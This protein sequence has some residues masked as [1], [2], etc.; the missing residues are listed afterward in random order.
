MRRLALLC[1][2]ILLPLEGWA[3]QDVANTRHN[4]STSGPGT[5]KSTS[6]TQVCVFCHTPH[7]AQPDAPLWNRQMS[8][9]SYTPYTSTTLQSAPPAIPTG[10]SKLCL[11]CHDGTVALSAMVNPPTG[12]TILPGDP[13]LETLQALGARGNLDTDLANDH[14]I[15]FAYSTALPNPELIDPPPADLPLEGG[16]VQCTT[17][18]DPHEA[19]LNPFL[20]RTTIGTDPLYLCTSCHDRKSPTLAWTWAA[21]SHAT[22]TATPSVGNPWAD[23]RTEWQG[24]NVAENGCLNCHTPHSAAAPPRLLKNVE[25]NTC[26]LCHDGTVAATDIQADFLKTYRHPVDT[27][28]NASHDATA[29]ENP[30]TMAFHAEC[31]DCHNP[32]GVADAA[33]MI[34]FNP[35]STADPHTAPPLANARIAGVPGVDVNGA[36]KQEIDFQ[37]ELCFKCHGLGAGP[38][39]NQQC[40]STLARTHVRHDGVRNIR[41]RVNPATAGLQSYHPLVENNQANNNGVG[42]Y[43][44]EG[45]PSPRTDLPT[46]INDSTALI[47]CTDCHG[48][49]VSPAAGGT[50]PNGPHGTNWEG[51]LAQQYTFNTDPSD[52]SAFYALCYKC[53]DEGLL[54]SN[55]SGFNHNGHIGARGAAC[56]DC[57]DPH[58]SHKYKRLIN[59]LWE[60]D[61]IFV[62]DCVRQKGGGLQPCEPATPEPIWIDDPVNPNQGE[63]WIK[64]HGSAHTP[65]TY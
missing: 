28:P 31:A 8:G 35:L 17:C 39:E 45:G 41:D 3:V 26:D 20:H 27:T 48:S 18:H 49:D 23:R 7:N 25:E 61:G 9:A 30:L 37:Y 47:Y 42:P 46:E 11:A 62:V 43:G 50:G 16:E 57:H 38:C 14:P 60:A 15:S 63:C 1:L 36:V 44:L 51:M 33:P 59:F 56:I 19:T 64:C 12:V 40:P 55:L 58:G 22:S 5:V 4:L 54:R 2:L 6:V 21:S 13:I 53:H 52:N 34:S 24:T 29:N 65:K 32:H 10:K